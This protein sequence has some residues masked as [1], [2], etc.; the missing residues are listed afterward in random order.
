MENW[1]TEWIKQ[2]I[3]TALKLN[4]GE[5]GGSYSEASIILCATLSALSTEVWPGKQIDRFRFVELLIKFL[6]DTYL[7]ANISIPLLV[8][9]LRN[10][11]RISESELIKS[12]YLGNDFSRVFVGNDV[13]VNE[14][15]VLS[16]CNTLNLKEIREHSYAN[17]L[18][19]ELRS[20]YVHEYSPGDRANSNPMT[21]RK[22]VAISYINWANEADRRIYFHIEWLSE[23][24]RIIAN[25]LDSESVSNIKKPDNW[26][27]SGKITINTEQQL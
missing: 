7:T 25:K 1:R 23:L 6:P 10:N 20:S 16:T 4:A 17:I 26:W 11:G 15:E 9:H 22:D 5:C 27:V 3:A 14:L 21:G 13:D 12:C 2:K 8:G 18:Y 19:V 24:A